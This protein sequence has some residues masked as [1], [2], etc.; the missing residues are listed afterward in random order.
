MLCLA[1]ITVVVFW[2]FLAGHA[3]LWNDFA[4]YTYPNQVFAARSV[5]Q[6]VMPWWNPFVLNGMPFIAD[7]QTGFFYP[8]NQLMYRLANGMLTATLLQSVVVLHYFV[9][10]IGMS[11]GAFS[12]RSSQT[13]KVRSRS[14]PVT[15]T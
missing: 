4:E 2:P 3:F 11:C 7:P 8:I 12:K 13:G 14:L 15:P 1:A 10:M 6:G 5:A 9:A